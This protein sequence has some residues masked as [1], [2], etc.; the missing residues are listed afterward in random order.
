M[1]DSGQGAGDIRIGSAEREAAL[2]QLSF[3]T[4][5]GRLSPDELAERSAAVEAAR[6]RG[7]LD[8]VFVDLPDADAQPYGPRPA[9]AAPAAAY[10]PVGMPRPSDAGPA[11]APAPYAGGQSATMSRLVAMSGSLALLAF[12]ACGFL[13]RGW[14]WAWIFFL[15]PGLVRAWYRDPGSGGRR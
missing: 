11:P 2:R 4:N 12:L 1:S 6:T 8:A 3:H 7:E 14:A 9:D 13:L 5:A 15:V 10:P